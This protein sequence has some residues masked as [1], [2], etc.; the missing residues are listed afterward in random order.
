[1]RD[2][3]NYLY[4]GSNPFGESSARRHVSA[5]AGYRAADPKKSTEQTTF[6]DVITAFLSGEATEARRAS[7]Q[8]QSFISRAGKSIFVNFGGSRQPPRPWQPYPEDFLATD[9]MLR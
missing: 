5:S 7:W 3:K 9:W 4:G 6:A 2:S 1:M 8:V